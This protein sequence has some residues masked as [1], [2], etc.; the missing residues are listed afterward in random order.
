MMGRGDRSCSSFYSKL[1]EIYTLTTPAMFSLC[2]AMSSDSLKDQLDDGKRY[3]IVI[4]GVVIVTTYNAHK[5]CTFSLTYIMNWL[6]FS[7]Q[8]NI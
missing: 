8:C 1:H 5:F 6:C 4:T 3:G 7:I 2:S